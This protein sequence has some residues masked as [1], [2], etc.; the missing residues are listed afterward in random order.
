MVRAI[1]EAVED[2][3]F[4]ITKLNYIKKS[5][6]SKLDYFAYLAFISFLDCFLGGAAI[7]AVQ[8][9]YFS[10]YAG[11]TTLFLCGLDFLNWDGIVTKSLY[12]CM[13]CWFTPF[14]YKCTLKG[15]CRVCWT[16]KKEVISAPCGCIIL[17][18]KCARPFKHCY[19]CSATCSW[20]DATPNETTKYE[21]DALI[22][23]S[24]CYIPFITLIRPYLQ[25][26]GQKFSPTPYGMI[27]KL[28]YQPLY[29]TAA[30]GIALLVLYLLYDLIRRWLMIIKSSLNFL[31][32]IPFF[33]WYC[34]WYCFWP[35]R[36]KKTDSIE[37]QNEDQEPNMQNE[38]ILEK[39]EELQK[40]QDDCLSKQ[41]E[42]FDQQK[43]YLK[44]IY[45]RQKDDLKQQ[46]KALN[47]HHIDTLLQRIDKFQKQQE[48]Q[49]DQVEIKDQ[50]K[51]RNTKCVICLD[52]PLLIALKPCGHV[53]ACHKCAKKLPVHGEC[54]ICRTVITGTLKVYFP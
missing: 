49:D 22:T 52:K 2:L 54:P 46:Q 45:N 32:K 11:V 29:W 16:N 26:F 30:L 13:F 53:C 21:R 1:V 35:K 42:E 14:F 43:E 8:S 9:F 50:A 12:V 27:T 15:N 5:S 47:Q 51:E 24:A 38:L 23:A 36:Q 4:T 6:K 48:L 34:L 41:Q 31:K 18:K 25:E 3:S 19:W 33:I 10:W 40:R 20:R 39:L 44:D 37:Y 28:L 17:C 7:F